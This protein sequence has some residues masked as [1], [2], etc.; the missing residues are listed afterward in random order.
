[1]FLSGGIKFFAERHDVDA[2]RTE[3]SAD[4]RRGVG[5]A[6]RDLQFD[7]SND[8]FSHTSKKSRIR[9]TGY[10]FTNSVPSAKVRLRQNP[11]IVIHQLAKSTRWKNMP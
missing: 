8:F 1:L 11:L 2:A 4:G 6:S 9:Q 5:L 10:L 3:R 7:V